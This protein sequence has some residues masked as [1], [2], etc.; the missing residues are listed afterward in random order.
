MGHIDGHVKELEL[1]SEVLM[2]HQYTFNFPSFLSLQQR[3]YL[4]D[5]APQQRGYNVGENEL[6]SGREISTV[7]V[8]S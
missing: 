3:G 6:I 7:I 5:G 8:L 2:W 4:S 1:M